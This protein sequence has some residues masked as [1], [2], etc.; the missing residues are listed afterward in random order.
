MSDAIEPTA[1]AVRQA[2]A[3]G[4]VAGAAKTL[5]GII[6]AD[7]GADWAFNDLITL[8]AGNG[9]RVE[10]LQL[11]RRAIVANPG[12]AG[13]HDRLGTLLSEQNDLTAGEWHFRRAL[14]L[15]GPEA[16]PLANLALNLMQQGR[17]AESDSAFREADRL[18][19]RTLRILAH[20]S[21]L[22]E[23]QGDLAGA[24]RLLDAA[25][26]ASTPAAINLLRAQ[27]LSR[28]GREAEAFAIIAAAP[29][30]NGDA[31]LERG[32][33]HERAGRYRE[34]WQD[35][36]EG[37]RR[38]AAE[39]GGL[40]YD[41]AGVAAFYGA[42]EAFFDAPSMA[43]LPRAGTRG[44][45]PQPIFI[46]GAPRSGTTLLEQVLSAHSAVRAGGERPWIG[47]LRVVAQRLCAEAGAF[48]FCLAATWSA[49]QR[50]LAA[51]LRD[52]YLARAGDAGLLAPGARFFT[53]KMPFNE[54]YLPLIRMAFPEASVVLLRRDPRDVAVSM[55][56]NHLSHGFNCGY[57]I[58][59]IVRHLA[60]TAALV[61]H[62]ERVTGLPVPEFRYEGLVA[63]QEGQTRQLLEWLELPFE[64]A[65][66]N[67]H[68]NRR[69]A[70]TP[71][72]AQVA[73]R[74]NPR[75]IGR[76]RRFAAE[77]DPHLPALEPLLTAGNYRP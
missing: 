41:A 51:I 11:A 64:D 69:Y 48:P 50:H 67:F 62:Y 65:C 44:D 15:G 29:T 58:E 10:A 32:R 16:A 56:S 57:R 3:R 23:V 72:Y 77:L 33:L 66:L 36:T 47:E 34:S 40:A 54:M 28:T 25:E 63:N 38:L 21:K 39:A 7:R 42:M 71:S 30:L 76:W 46:V 22:R 19:P 1:A 49:D 53:D 55:I 35:Y 73:E 43:Q 75:A 2:I 5:A 60:A 37:K 24:E 27:Y 31:F 70:P 45:I 12:N 4:D 52:H 26:A 17:T 61:G 20:W 6:A 14:D 9:R 59:D 18:A 13:A 74:L 68:Q 8:L